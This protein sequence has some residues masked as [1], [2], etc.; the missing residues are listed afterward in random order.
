MVYLVC[1]LLLRDLE[2]VMF[3]LSKW[4]PTIQSRFCVFLVKKHASNLAL[5]KFG[6]NVSGK[7]DD[8]GLSHRVED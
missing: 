2:R 4:V 1:H 3:K 6:S 8:K 5:L 7:M